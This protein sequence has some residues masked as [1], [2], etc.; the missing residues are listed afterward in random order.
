[1]LLGYITRD[2]QKERIAMTIQKKESY[3]GEEESK[4]KSIPLLIGMAAGT[5]LLKEKAKLKTL[6]QFSDGKIE[7]GADGYPLECCLYEKD[8]ACFDL[9]AILSAQD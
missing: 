6:K 1:M 2:L 4:I 7:M 8:A 9:E 3:I 5:K